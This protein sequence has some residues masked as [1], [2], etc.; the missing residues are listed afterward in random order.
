[1][2]NGNEM[3]YRKIQHKI[4][5]NIAQN[6]YIFIGFVDFFINIEYNIRDR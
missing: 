4:L 2:L 6:L 1:M 5:C 3:Q